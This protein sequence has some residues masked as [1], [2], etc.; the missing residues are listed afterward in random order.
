MVVI[1]MILEEAVFKKF[2]HYPS[3]LKPYS[4][5][6]ILAACDDCGKVRIASKHTYRARCRSCSKKGKKRP[7]FGRTGNKHYNFGK[8]GADSAGYTGGKK[9]AQARSD[10]KRRKLGSNILMPIAEG[11][12]EHHVTNAYV[13]GIPAE[14][15][16]RL[17]GYK[18]R[19][20]RTLVLQW[21]KMH[22]KKKYKMVL[23]VLA[24][25]SLK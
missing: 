7:M 16:K 5:N 19:K 24:K 2:G 9:V 13:I 17:S 6:P 1:E 11:E 15:H 10:S 23:C 8:R 25:E 14:V 21:L 22:D 12:I 18:R 4:H 3:A 20:H